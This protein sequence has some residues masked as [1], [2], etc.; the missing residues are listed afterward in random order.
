VPSRIRP[1]DEQVIAEL[2]SQLQDALQRFVAGEST[3]IAGNTIGT[4]ALRLFE[5]VLPPSVSRS[6]GSVFHGDS[7]SL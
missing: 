1:D 2:T 5:L 4:V 6:E 7:L 3:A